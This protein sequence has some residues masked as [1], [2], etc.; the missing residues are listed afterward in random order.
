MWFKYLFG[1]GIRGL[2][3]GLFSVTVQALV[4]RREKFYLSY[5]LKAYLGLVKSTIS[6]PF[7]S[8][9]SWLYCYCFGANI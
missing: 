4:L 5:N 2:E 3:K 7:V 9:F 8:W 6:K 1:D